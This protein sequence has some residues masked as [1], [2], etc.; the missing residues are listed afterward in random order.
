M[1]NLLASAQQHYDFNLFNGA[2]EFRSVYIQRHRL[3]DKYNLNLDAGSYLG[4]GSNVWTRWGFRGNIQRT[5]SDFYKVDVGFMYNHI[6]YKNEEIIE[7]KI[8]TKHITR[9]EYR[10]FQSLSVS[11]PRFK[12][13][14]LQH[15]LRLEERIFTQV[16]KS[17][18]DFKMRLRYRLMHQ[19][20]FDGQPIAPK[21]FF[22]RTFAEFNFNIY[23]EAEDVFWVRGRYC[24]GFGYQ[25]SSKLSADANYYFEHTKTATDEDQV[26]TNIFQISLRQTVYWNK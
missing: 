25:F 21:S 24:M 2:G 17:V 14:A 8:E 19:G 5:L 9:H 23:E 12:S 18:P 1:I 3:N 10:P 11:Y 22:Y 26:I 7:G 6:N 4:L 16:H 20:R 15:R 13:S